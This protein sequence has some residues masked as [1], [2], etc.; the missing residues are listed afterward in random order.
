MQDFKCLASALLRFRL[1]FL[2]RP[3]SNRV[4]LHIKVDAHFHYWQ[5]AQCETLRI[6]LEV[7]L[8]HGGVGTLAEFQLEDVDMCVSA[9]HHVY[10][11][12]RRAHLQV[13]HI[14]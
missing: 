3:I 13:N 9:Q 5:S 8:P 12:S 6:V 14:G 10:T 7:N 1:L 4:L 11:A 2:H